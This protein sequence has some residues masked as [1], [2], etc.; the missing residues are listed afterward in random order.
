MKQ[1][2]ITSLGIS[3][4][5]YGQ[6]EQQTAWDRNQA[7]LLACPQAKPAL[8]LSYI[9]QRCQPSRSPYSLPISSPQDIPTAPSFICLP[10]SCIGN[11]FCGPE[12]FFELLVCDACLHRCP[13]VQVICRIQIFAALPSVFVQYVQRN[14]GVQYTGC[15]KN[16]FCAY[17]SGVII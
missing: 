13:Q 14:A 11:H 5:V 10:I 2:H 9:N 6:R 1:R 12:R 3:L 17:F 8:S 7:F 16:V 15:V 4:K